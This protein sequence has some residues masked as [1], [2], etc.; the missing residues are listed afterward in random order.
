MWINSQTLVVY[1][2]VY[3]I[4]QAF[5]QMS[6]PEYP[7]DQDFESV[8]VFPVVPTDP[9]AYDPIT[10]NLIEETP[11][12]VDGQWVQV[13]SV[14]PATPE[15]IAERE[16]AAVQANKAQAE[17]LLQQTDWTQMPDVPLVNKEA[18]TAYRAEL[19]AIALNP[20]VS[21]TEWPEKPE[22]IWTEE[23]VITPFEEDLGEE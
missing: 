22:E 6:F 2:Y 3:E 1:N 5:P 8:G 13:W 20:P 10:E 19:R 9:P 11:Q 14:E 4:R 16:A 18:F 12:Y 21:V 23:T 17:Q 15:E 7:T